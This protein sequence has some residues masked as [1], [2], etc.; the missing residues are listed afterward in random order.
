MPKL[1]ALLLVTIVGL[2]T[3]IASS[4][5]GGSATESPIVMY[6]TATC[7]YC[8]QARAYFTKRGVQWDERDIDTSDKARD[9]WKALGG[10]ATPLIVINDQRL[11]GFSQKDIDNELTKLGK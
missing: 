4:S 7:G 2:W 11:V 3:S 9:E 1:F 10:F 5:A 6:A 8:A